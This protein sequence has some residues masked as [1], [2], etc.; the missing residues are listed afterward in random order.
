MILLT[1]RLELRPVTLEIVNADLHRRDE[2][3]ALLDAAIGAGWPMELMDVAA[4]EWLKRS[5]QND[6][7]L[8]PWTAWYWITRSPRVLIGASG[9]KSRPQNGEVEFGYG[10]LP[11]FQRQGFATEAI[12]AMIEWA[13]ANGAERLIAETLPEL[14]ASQA[15]LRKCGFTSCGGASDP[16]VIRFERRRVC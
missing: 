6:P 5:L 15:L 9:F 10:V 13:F 12:S 16:G 3:P 11:L 8:A 4:M 7:A 1:P 14:F 2:L